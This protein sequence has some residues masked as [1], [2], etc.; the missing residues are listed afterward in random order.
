[1]EQQDVKTKEEA[2]LY[3]QEIHQE[4]SMQEKKKTH[5]AEVR[6]RSTEKQV[7]CY[8]KEVE[9]YDEEKTVTTNYL[10]SDNCYTL[11]GL[12]LRTQ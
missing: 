3:A 7:E 1:M 10:M 5:E 11:I 9:R 2:E 6:A 4:M 8:R 12:I